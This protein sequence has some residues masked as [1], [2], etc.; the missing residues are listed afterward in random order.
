MKLYHHCRPSDLE[1][2]AEK[3]LFPHIAKETAISL[4]QE[5]VWLTEDP[6]S[7]CTRTIACERV[8]A[9]FER[10]LNEAASQESTHFPE[11]GAPRGRPVAPSC[12]E[13]ARHPLHAG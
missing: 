4:G 2:I 6:S 7:R 8:R 11:L 9:L 1:S 3:S 13:A 10:S 5:I 12:H